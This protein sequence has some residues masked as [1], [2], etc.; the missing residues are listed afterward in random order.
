VN[1][2]ALPVA[3]RLTE[4]DDLTLRTL[5]LIDE[6]TV[7][8]QRRRALSAYARLARQDPC[9]AEIVRLVLASRRQRHNGAGNVIRPGVWNAGG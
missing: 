8:E 3:D 4:L 5:A 1:G 2:Q 9:V 6:T 7:A